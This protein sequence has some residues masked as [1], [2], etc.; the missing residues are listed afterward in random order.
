M[1]TFA[2]VAQFRSS[3][4]RKA[5]GGALL[6]ADY[7]T[8]ALTDI[9]TTG[10]VLT[11][12]AGYKSMG[13][14]TTDGMA[15]A[16][17][18]EKSEIKGWGDN[19]PSRID[20]TSESASLTC[21]AMETKAAVFDAFY[22]VDQAAIVPKSGTG[23]IAFDKALLQTVRD[24]R[25]LALGRD[26]NKSNGLDIYLGIHFPRANLSQS[27]EQTLANTDA[28]LSYPL[29][30]QAQADDAAG[31]AVRLFWGGPGLAGLLTDMGYAAAVPTVSSISPATGPAAG[32]TLVK[33]TGSSFV[34]AT[35]VFFAAVAAG[36]FDVINANTISAIAPAG[37]AGAK[38]VTVTTP[39]GTSPVGVT[40]TYA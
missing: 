34:G 21:T 25:V 9:C 6:V 38:N 33:I 3:L 30:V 20:I 12:P 31:T 16:N 29:M 4:I 10:G 27:G 22:N 5:L 17:E 24:K 1:S 36:A 18:V 11:I 40:Y 23:T 28:A 19:F 2:E 35:N 26:I 14:L 37:T 39:A 13:K 15:S 8:A 7:S 32:G